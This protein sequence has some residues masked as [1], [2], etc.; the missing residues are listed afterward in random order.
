MDGKKLAVLMGPFVGELYWEGGRFAPMLPHMIQSE[1]K[2]K[3][4]I[5][6]IILTRKERFDLYGKFADILV[7][8]KIPLS[9][10]AKSLPFNAL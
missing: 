5:T 6:Y 7:P 1:Y 4:D 10:I 3:K 9:A 8:L 2:F